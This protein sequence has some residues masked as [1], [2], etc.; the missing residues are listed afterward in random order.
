MVWRFRPECEVTSFEVDGNRIV[1]ATAGTERIAANCFCLAGGIWTATLAERLG[2]RI[3]LEP[4]KGQM[5]L[6]KCAA[7]PVG[8]MVNEGPRYVIPRNDGHVLVGSTMEEVG[9]DLSTTPAAIEGLVAFAGEILPQLAGSQPVATWAGLRPAPVDGFP[10]LG[11]LPGLANAYIAAGHF[12]AGIA[13]A[14]GT[15]HAMAQLIAGEKPEIDLG[16]FRV[17]R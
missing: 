7:P 2:Y 8:R 5:A 12:R 3:G 6:L 10:F 4:F 16:P 17:G 14:P 11:G 15:A 13:L 1:A 9:F